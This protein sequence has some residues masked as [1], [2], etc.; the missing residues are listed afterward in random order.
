MKLQQN[1]KPIKVTPE[2]L[3]ALQAAMSDSIK[4]DF[5]KERTNDAPKKKRRRK[6]KRTKE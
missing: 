1:S 4:P 2:I 6:Q 3:K 5:S